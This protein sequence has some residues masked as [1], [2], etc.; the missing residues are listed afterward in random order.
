[1]S[2]ECMIRGGKLV[3]VTSRGTLHDGAIVIKNGKIEAVDEW[4]S[5]QKKYPSI[6]VIDYS[7]YVITPALVDCHTHLLEFA[8]T[9]LYPVTSETHFLGGKTILFEALSSGITALGE[10]ICGHPLSDFSIDDYRDAVKDFPMDI[11]FAATSIS[12]GFD[13]LV[14]FT[15][16]TKSTPVSQK[17][18]SNTALVTDMARQ[19]DYPGENIFINATPANFKASEVPHAGEIIYSF[20]DLKKIADIYHNEDKQ[21]GV[22]VAGETAIQMALD[23]GIDILHHAHGIRNKQIDQAAKQNIC[24]IATP[25]GGTH[26][27]PNSPENIHNLM[28][29]NIPVSIATDAYLPPYPNIPW[30]DVDNQTLYGP[31]SLMPIAHPTMEHLKA[32]GYNENDILALLTKNSATILGKER[33]FGSLAEGLD[34]NLIVTGGVP[35]LEITNVSEIKNVFFRGEW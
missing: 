3:T 25:L 23:A 6:N 34:A 12:I 15:S 17:E 32:N 29:N 35:G 1:M 10:Q 24:I 8:P 26:L 4:N 5:L 13:K 33:Q 31:D 21:I 19:S 16:V 11:S 20:D 14:H 9:T 2:E 7:D 18:L 27:Q 30:L 22:H 28:S